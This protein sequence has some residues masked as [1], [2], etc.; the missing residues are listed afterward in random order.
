MQCSTASTLARHC[1]RMP[2]VEDN[3]C[4]D[5]HTTQCQVYDRNTKGSQMIPVLQ[6]TKLMFMRTVL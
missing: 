1:L 3:F 6:L 4:S 2:Q 5:L